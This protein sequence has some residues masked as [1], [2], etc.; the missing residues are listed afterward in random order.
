MEAGMTGEELVEICAT[1]NAR[2]GGGTIWADAEGI[3]AWWTILEPIPADEFQV[4]LDHWCM[5]QTAG[6]CPLP[7]QIIF[8]AMERRRIGIQDVY[9]KRAQQMVKDSWPHEPDGAALQNL[10]ES[11]SLDMQQVP[12]TWTRP[13]PMV[14]EDPH[15][16]G[17][18]DD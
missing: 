15:T 1:V 11:M 9:Q 18:S 2:Y 6:D 14:A 13:V 3:T 16:F 4:A 5:S 10:M 17:G 7:G 12:G 8:L